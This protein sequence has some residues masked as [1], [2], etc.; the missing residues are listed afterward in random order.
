MEFIHLHNH[1][2]YSILD[3]AIT[4]DKLVGKAVELKMPAVAIT[5][6]GNMFGAVEFYQAA[7]SKGIKPIIGQ[8]FYV[9]PGSRFD[10]D[11]RTNGDTS[12]HLLLLAKNLQGYKNLIKLSS[13]GYL[14]GF[15]YKPRID[16]E[17]L[18][19]YKEGLICS[20]ACLG[21]EI[22]ILIL[23]GRIEEAHRA[24]G[25]LKELFG[26]DNFYLEMQDHGLTEQRT[27]N[28]ELV[29]ISSSQGIPLIATNDCH[30]LNKAD[31][32]SHEVLLCVQTGKTLDDEKR[33]R[34]AS[35]QFY[36][37]SPEEMHALFSD[38][39]DAL[40][41]TCEIGEMIDL[42]LKLGDTILPHFA[43]PDNFT[44]DSYLKHLVLEGAERRFNDIPD[45][46][47]KRIEYELSIITK[48]N[49]S[50]Y[51]LI[52][53]DF[54]RF[55]KQNNI[56][57]GPGRG[58]AAG[59]M[60]SYCLGI[61]ELNPIRY[62]LLFERFLNPDRNEMPDMDIDF[63]ANRREEVIDYVK[64]KYGED[65]VSQ[66]I[67][68]NTMKA[69]AVIKDVARVLNIP[70][71]EANQIS[72]LITEDSLKEVLE[73]S[74]EFRSLYTGSNKGKMLVDISLTLEGLVRSAGKHA[75]GVVISREPLTEYVPLYRDAKD[76]SISTQFEKGGLELTG[77]VKMD[78]LGLKNLSII[79]NC[80]KLIESKGT[81]FDIRS[82]PLDDEETFRL[83]QE[84]NTLGV[85]QLESSG[86]QNILRKLGPTHFEDIIAIN[87][88]YRPG[89][90]DSGM[91]DDY[92]A[93]KRNPEKISY[94]H[95]LLEPILRDTLGVIVYQEQVMLISQELAGFS[96]PEADKLRKAMGKKRPEII[97]E[98]EEKFIRGAT[99]KKIDINLAKDVFDLISKFAR[100][101]FNKS[102]SA[103]YALVS[104]QTAYLKAHYPLEYMT[105]LLSA[106][107]DK[108]DDIIKY[109]NDCRSNGIEVLPPDIN[110][111]DYDF[112][113]END[114]IRFGLGAIK[115]IGEKAIESILT[116]RR[117]KGAFTTLKDF[118]EDIDLAAVNRGAME[119]LIMAGAMDAIQEKRSQ[120]FN[121]VDLLI[122]AAKR[123]QVD[124]SSGQG[125][126]FE[127]GDAAPGGAG[128]L[129]I[130]LPRTREWF[131]NE[132]LNHEKDVL[133][134]YISGH[135]L[136]KYEDEIRGFSC[137]SIS[138]LAEN[139]EST[140]S[141]VGII[142]NLKR[143]T[144]KNGSEFAIAVVE[145][146]EGAIEAIFFPR[147]FSKHEH[148]ITSDEP[149]MVTGSVEIDGNKP[150]K[151]KV[152]EVKS[153]DELRKESISALHIKLNLVGVDDKMLN[154]LKSIIA[155]NRGSCQVFFHLN[156]KKGNEKI[157]KAHSSFNITP[158]DNLI[159]ELSQIVGKDS[160]R[161]S[162]RHHAER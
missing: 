58:S 7:R 41:N 98:M 112:T 35:D 125:N 16:L 27:V 148:L 92:I 149:I 20:T 63:C 161:Y 118:L 17:I 4:I 21:G 5:D 11:P 22:P 39:P 146:M 24:A 121:S 65:R 28:S 80:I 38:Y 85:F 99:K 69:K 61:T 82:I 153:L 44:L 68:F 19:T 120:L 136:A 43:V 18:E 25:R 138:Q 157:I 9:S 144:T 81:A 55:A 159:R 133:G 34:F 14:E 100:Y 62:N 32:K 135:A 117:K 124:K 158:S 52:V 91:V 42:E 51:F 141:I 30:Y 50:G 74:E 15:Y 132:K 156:E 155:R 128:G 37:K 116:A 93:R 143:R 123:I 105:S 145:D 131:D 122:E 150:K 119:S 109:I 12:Y 106:Q 53:W 140:I 152:N 1:S 59:S 101:G 111:S 3:G 142:N 88:L 70:F 26:P 77:L 2:D 115:G 64:K 23:R 130:E 40:H 66:V 13:S 49:F 71:N 108:Q 8:E 78:F 110:H 137:T 147:V 94:P 84:A 48:M 45:T 46:V 54:I 95:Q 29:K 96:L 89:P 97:Q 86:M 104:Y 76:G 127:T 56:P 79:D 33:M 154:E 72:K 67:T 134:I 160:I 47:L 31:V 83:L 103:A 114:A 6:H 102:H 129:S 151:I 73:T 10:R 107:P 162:I 90:L 60:V 139:G 36:F 113:I 57:V 87:A 75:A 126:L